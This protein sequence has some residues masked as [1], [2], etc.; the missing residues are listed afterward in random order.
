MVSFSSLCKKNKNI[1]TTQDNH[2]NNLLHKHYT[3]TNQ[4]LHKHYTYT[5]QVLVS[6]GFVKK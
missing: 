4:V 5:N 2:R 6:Q 1:F 3:Y